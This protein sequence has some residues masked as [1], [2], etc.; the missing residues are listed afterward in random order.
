MDFG[1]QLAM[2]LGYL[3]VEFREPRCREKIVLSENVK[4][5]HTRAAGSRTRVS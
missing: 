4:M 1:V 2:G 5:R 3:Q